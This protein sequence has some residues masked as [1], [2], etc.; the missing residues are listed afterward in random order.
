MKTIIEKILFTVFVL[1]TF[2]QVASAQKNSGKAKDGKVKADTSSKKTHVDTIHVFDDTV[3][4]ISNR[5]LLF[6]NE[7]IKKVM[8]SDEYR[9]AGDVISQYQMLIVNMNQIF[10]ACRRRW[11][12]NEKVIKPEPENNK[13]NL[14]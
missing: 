12:L 3:E 13:V 7:V 14:P 9:K 8:T 10:D 11:Q 5:D 1:T 2:V 6:I 4:Y